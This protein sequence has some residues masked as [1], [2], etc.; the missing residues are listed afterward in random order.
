MTFARRQQ[1][2]GISLAEVL[3]VITILGIMYMVVGPRISDVRSRAS[4]RAARQELVSAFASAR[5]SAMQKGKP[6][7]LTLT[8]TSATVSVLSGLA[9][10]A[11]Q[12][13][14]VGFDK[15]LNSSLSAVAGAPMT[16]SFDAHGLL[17]GVPAN[18]VQKYRLLNGTAADTLCISPAGVILSRT[19]QL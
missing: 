12:V 8:T 3:V 1:R 14:S 13:Y 16:V 7:T 2:A 15:Q 17:T 5:A 18:T 11:V 4:L 10:A 19:C 9:G 6:S